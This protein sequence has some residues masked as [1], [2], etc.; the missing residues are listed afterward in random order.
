M[1]MS[2]VQIMNIYKT[3]SLFMLGVSSNGIWSHNIASQS[4][5]GSG[6]GA[7][8]RKSEAGV[9]SLFPLEGLARP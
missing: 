9:I 7:S 4:T 5:G 2:I 8:R 3:S 6:R 1:I